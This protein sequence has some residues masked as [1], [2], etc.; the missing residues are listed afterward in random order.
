M[1]LFLIL[2]IKYETK[3]VLF[4]VNSGKI[5]LKINSVKHI[6]EIRKWYNESKILLKQK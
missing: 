1:F 3:N 2:R 5:L 4:V 6:R